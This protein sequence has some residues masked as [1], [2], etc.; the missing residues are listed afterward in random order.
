MVW[1]AVPVAILAGISGY[2][3]V[4][5]Y[6]LYFGLAKATEQRLRREYLTFAFTCAAAAAYDV[7]CVGLYDTRSVD[8]GI[9]W[10][11]GNWLTAACI[12]IA[13]QTFVWDFLR[14][15]MPTVLRGAG[16][17]LIALGLVVA[18][19]DSP[20]TFTVAKPAIKQLEVFGRSVVY[21]EA[22]AGVVDQALM[23]LFFC[24]YCANVACL[25]KYFVSR[26][27]RA[28]RGQLG[29][30]VATAIASAAATNDFL[31]TGQVYRFLYAFEYGFAAILAAMGYVLF[32]R[33]GE[34]HESVRTLNDEL[35][36]TNS[37]LV[38]ALEQAN[39]SI[40]AKTEF[41]A[42]VSHELRTPLNAIINLPEQLAQEFASKSRASCSA[43]GAVFELDDGEVLDDR[44]NCGACGVPGLSRGLENYFVVEAG[45]ATRWLTTVTRA[46]RNLLGLVDD[47]L[48]TSKLELG[49]A[50]VIPSRFDVLEMIAEVIESTQAIAFPKGIRVRM[51]PS[52]TH[53]AEN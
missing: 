49:R 47:V 46:G 50:M 39:A 3:A 19:W 21:N 4:L 45:T 26:A 30:L 23:L 17:V 13:Y 16:H 27:G 14:R 8:S 6:G 36:K 2:T 12:G 18:F 28:H 1:N 15:P 7:T 11:R 9:F 51:E 33:F 5:F 41:L 24:I 52:A 38:L 10:M 31:V 22:E 32:M 53:S 34:L 37:D 42:S 43:C 44:A 40:R 35:Q 25:G 20:Y 29:F 48:D